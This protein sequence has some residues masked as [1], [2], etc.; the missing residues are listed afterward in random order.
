MLPLLLVRAQ[1]MEEDTTKAEPFFKSKKLHSR[2]Y[3]GAEGNFSQMLVNKVGFHLG[4]S[5]NWVVQKRFVVSV[6]YH[7]TTSQNNIQ[8]YVMPGLNAPDIFLIH[9]FAGP[10]FGYIFFHEKKFSLHPEVSGGW[11][12]ARYAVD[13]T[14]KARSDFGMV[15]PAVYGIYNASPY[16]RFGIGVRYNAAIGCQLGEL[17]SKDMSGVGGLIFIRVGAFN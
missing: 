8:E 16:F 17:R 1:V 2:G 4:F 9:H 15:I 7:T 6:K 12:L 3:V 13:D 10:G 14:R 11:A 5:L